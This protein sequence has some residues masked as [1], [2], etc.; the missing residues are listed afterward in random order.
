[1]TYFKMKAYKYA[2]LPLLLM[3]TAIPVSSQENSIIVGLAGDPTLINSAITTEINSSVVGAQV[4]STI[5]RLNYK[6]EPIPSLAKSWEISPDGKTYTFRFFEGIKWHDGTPF[7]AEDVAWSLQNLNRKFNGPAGGLLEAVQEMKVI[8]P[9]T[10]VFELSQ[11]YPPLLRGLAYFNSAMILPKHIFDNGSAPQENPAN[12][13]PV[14]TGPFIFKEFKK[15][16]HI[17]LERNPDYHLEGPWVDRLVYQIIPND[18]A[19]GLALEKGDIDYIPYHVMPLGEVDRLSKARDITV[20][21]QKRSIAGQYQAFLNTRSGPLSHKRVRQALYFAMDRQEL[22]EKAGFGH[23]VV[24]KGGGLSSELPIF[25]TDQVPQYQHDVARANEMLDE[26]GYPRGQDGK[27]FSLRVSYSLSEGPMANVSKLLRAQFAKVGVEVIDEGMEMSAWRE[28]A[29][30]KW[31]FDVTMGSYASGPD[32]A[33]GAA[34]FYT[35]DRIV[36]RSGFNASG[37]CN[38]EL[39]KLFEAAGKE[40]N[41]A[42]RINLYHQAAA[43]LAEDVPHWWFWDR[44]YPIAFRSGL[45]GITQ[46]ITG[47][48]TM[49]VVKWTE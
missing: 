9:L 37:Y 33:T 32:P 13:A 19:R 7:T 11:P 38:P 35:C 1:M 15:G 16:S 45:D 22:L 5:V 20:A 14:G 44:Y 41:E 29:Y 6:G 18:A 49:D 4:Y 47:Y 31:D 10:V 28:K 21:F 17:T 40:L 43:I 36:P 39:D 34:G 42:N 30:V 8:D 27:R 12:L 23:G 46:D 3:S 2:F 26:A 24:S 48:G 25:Y